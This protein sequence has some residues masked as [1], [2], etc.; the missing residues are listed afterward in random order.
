VLIQYRSRLPRSLPAKKH[1]KRRAAPIFPNPANEYT[2]TWK[3][4]ELPNHPFAFD[5][6]LILA[7]VR[8]EIWKKR[9][10]VNALS[11]SHPLNGRALVQLLRARL[12]LFS[13]VLL[14]VWTNT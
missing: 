10:E 4:K 9:F 1:K 8:T 13:H 12:R 2:E 6:L 11:A 5:P 7:L 3:E 14:V